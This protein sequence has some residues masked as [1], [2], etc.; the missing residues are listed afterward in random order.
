MVPAPA[1]QSE[2][3]DPLALVV[4]QKQKQKNLVGPWLDVLACMIW[5]NYTPLFK[6]KAFCLARCFGLYGHFPETLDALLIHSVLQT[7][8]AA[9]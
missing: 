5:H 4:K 2:A 7:K 3:Q 1:T 6:S 9:S 8:A